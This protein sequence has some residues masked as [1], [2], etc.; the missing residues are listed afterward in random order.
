MTNLVP[1]FSIFARNVCENH[2]EKIAG[3][4]E[5]LILSSVSRQSFLVSSMIVDSAEYI[6]HRR[7]FSRTGVNV[8]YF[9]LCTNDYVLFI[10]LSTISQPPKYTKFQI[11]ISKFQLIIKIQI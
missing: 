6:V 8:F 10:E 7:I 11:L 5:T 4:T 2:V 3:E 1:C 9:A